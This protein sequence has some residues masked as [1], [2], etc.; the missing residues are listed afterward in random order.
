V[1]FHNV[2]NETY[3]E[4]TTHCDSLFLSKHF[5]YLKRKQYFNQKGKQSSK[6]FIYSLA[7]LTTP[8]LT[9]EIDMQDIQSAFYIRHDPHHITFTFKFREEDISFDYVTSHKEISNYNA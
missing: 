2:K 6:A 5:V 3:Q 8:I 9:L 7:N 1:F 4:Q